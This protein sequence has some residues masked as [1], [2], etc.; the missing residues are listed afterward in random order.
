MELFGTPVK[1]GGVVTPVYVRWKDR[2]YMKDHALYALATKSPKDGILGEPFPVPSIL[3]GKLDVKRLLRRIPFPEPRDGVIV[4]RRVCRE[5]FV[6]RDDGI[7]SFVPTRTIYVFEVAFR[8]H[9]HALI[10]DVLEYD[11]G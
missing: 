10:R 7:G 6:S 2:G 9:G 3:P 5:G 1:V 11:L 4:G 8:S